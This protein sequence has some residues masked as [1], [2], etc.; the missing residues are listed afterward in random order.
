VFQE[1][2]TDMDPK[3][4]KNNTPLGRH[5]P[6]PAADTEAELLDQEWR[7][8]VA[9]ASVGEGAGLTASEDT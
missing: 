3:V 5:I 9:A 2:R 8:G 6:T 7:A 4:G 1:D